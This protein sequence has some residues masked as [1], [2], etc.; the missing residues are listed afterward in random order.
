LATLRAWG[1][2]LVLALAFRLLELAFFRR[3]GRLARR[4]ADRLGVPDAADLPRGLV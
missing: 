3:V 4:L 2:F 1:R